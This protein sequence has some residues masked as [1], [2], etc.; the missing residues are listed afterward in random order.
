MTRGTTNPQ[1]LRR[2]DRWL[3][4]TQTARL[5][6][7]TDPL[8]VDLGFGAV[9]TTT[10]E[11]AARLRKIR[12]DVRVVGLEI[13]PER[14]AAAAR[15]AEPPGLSFGVGGFE[16]AGLRPVLVRAMNVLRQ[17]D[18]TDVAAA[19]TRMGSA[20]APDGLVIEGTCD[21]VG[22][23][24]SWVVLPA[25]ATPRALVLAA[26]TG[27]LDRPAAFAARL[28]KALIHRNV[29]GEPVHAFLAAADAAWDRAAAWSSFGPRERWRR[30]ARDLEASGWPVL[31]GPGRWRLGELAVSWDAVAPRSGHA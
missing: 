1:R 31:D 23:I 10:V 3:A 6:A 19:W 28:P 20:L 14:V 7:A 24:A 30:A 27:S 22:R 18:E 26:R 15:F 21:E 29:D 13:D 8:V 25:S 17:Y 5:L 4:G 11:L 9:P 12:P 16:L 2:V